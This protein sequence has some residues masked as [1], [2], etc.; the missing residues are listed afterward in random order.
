MAD[1]REAAVGFGSTKTSTVIPAGNAVGASMADL[2]GFAPIKAQTPF[3]AI[4]RGGFQAWG[5]I[6]VIPAAHGSISLENLILHKSRVAACKDRPALAL[7]ADAMMQPIDGSSGSTAMLRTRRRRKQATTDLLATG[8]RQ[9]IP[10][11]RL[12]AGRRGSRRLSAKRWP[13]R[14]RAW[15]APQRPKRSSSCGFARPEGFHQAVDQ[16]RGV[17]AVRIQL[18]VE[19]RHHDGGAGRRRDEDR[20]RGKG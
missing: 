11:R 7:R 9:L 12:G 18:G 10:R 20:E 19:L 16:T 6:S 1:R 17:G 8:N 4:R 2:R 3:P 13:G 14:W 5:E 15:A